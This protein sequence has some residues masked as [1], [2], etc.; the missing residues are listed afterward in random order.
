MAMSAPTGSKPEPQEA[1]YIQFKCL[2][3]GAIGEDGKPALN[4]YSAIIT[5]GH[6][7]PGAQVRTAAA[8]FRI[9]SLRATHRP[10]YTQPVYRIGK[11]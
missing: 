6:D 9:P 8:E 3:D 5:A 10:C 2:P 11:Q 1:R 7:F 4:K